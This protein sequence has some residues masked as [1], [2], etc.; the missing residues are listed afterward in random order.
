MKIQDGDVICV[1]GAPRRISQF[2]I[3]GGPEFLDRRVRD[4]I[5]KE[6]LAKAK[7]IIGA[8]PDE[9]KP[10]RLCI[11]D[12]RSRW[13]SC[14]GIKTIS[15]SWRLS[16]APLEIMHYVIIHECCHIVEMNHSTKFWALVEKYFPNYK[17]ARKWLR[18]NG[19][20]LLKK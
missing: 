2:E 10:K 12:T 1:F 8:M 15:L 4:K 17:I 7:E 14:S 13:G 9:L 11:R 19:N 5:K 18:N 16:F 20:S 6:F 3:G